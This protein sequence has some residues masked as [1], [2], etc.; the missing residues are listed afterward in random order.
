MFALA[1]LVFLAHVA[2][3]SL[4]GMQRALPELFG[5]PAMAASLCLAVGVW[6]LCLFYRPE[7][8]KSARATRPAR[9][10]RP[11]AARSG[12]SSHQKPADSTNTIRSRHSAYQAAGAPQ[13]SGAMSG[14]T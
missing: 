14:C 10:Q 9:A 1:V 3:E 11:L 8:R 2:E 5:R 13:S 6:L 12:S 4:T 7:G